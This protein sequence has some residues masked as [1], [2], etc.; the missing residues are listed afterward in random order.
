MWEMKQL[1]GGQALH[2]VQDFQRPL[3]VGDAD[4]EELKEEYAELELNEDEAPF[5]QGHPS[6][7]GMSLQPIKIS[8]VPDGGLQ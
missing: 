6:A 7:A 8:R 5:L 2:L 4:P 3:D 1:K